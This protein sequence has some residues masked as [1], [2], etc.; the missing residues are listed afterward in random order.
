MFLLLE[1]TQKK[2]LFLF[3]LLVINNEN[4]SYTPDLRSERSTH[5]AFVALKNLT[6]HHVDVFWINYESA[7]IYY[8]TMGPNGRLALDTYDTHPWVF[9][10]SDTGLFMHVEKKEVFW[11]EPWTLRRLQTR[12]QVSIQFPVQSLKTIAMFLIAKVINDE[13][14]VEQL[15][16]PKSLANELKT[17]LKKSKKYQTDQLNRTPP[18]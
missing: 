1:I 4:M 11:P 15:D 6:Q 3:F 8:A 5:Q 16:L 12:T 14:D 9:R 2:T 10:D 18:T 17:I 7:L 13:S